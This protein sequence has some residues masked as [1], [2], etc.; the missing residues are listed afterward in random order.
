MP[1]H[2]YCQVEAL[3]LPEISLFSNFHDLYLK[4]SF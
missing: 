2:S 1:D 3:P 4:C